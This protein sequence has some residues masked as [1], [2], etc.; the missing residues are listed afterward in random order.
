[1]QPSIHHNHSHAHNPAQTR[2]HLA[3]MHDLRCGRYEAACG[4]AVE[5]SCAVPAVAK[6]TTLLSI[7]KLSAKLAQE[8]RRESAAAGT[9]TAA[10]TSAIRG[11]GAGA[12]SSVGKNLFGADRDGVAA[13]AEEEAEEAEVGSAEFE[14]AVE[15]LNA[16][17]AVIR[18]QE[19]VYQV[20]PRYEFS[21]RIFII[22]FNYPPIAL[23]MYHLTLLFTCLFILVLSQRGAVPRPPQECI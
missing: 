14:E 4:A 6:A 10:L 16:D 17:L 2:P 21:F 18:T 9:G 19:I 20:L 22:C 7:A 5:A 13:A 1:V 23:F 15:K 8:K 11:T 12:K 3:W